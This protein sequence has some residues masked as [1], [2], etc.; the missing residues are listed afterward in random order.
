VQT[1]GSGGKSSDPGVHQRVTLG[2]SFDPKSNSLN[3]LRLVLATVVLAVHAFALGAFGREPLLH[4][5][6]FAS[7]AVYGFFGISGFLIAGSAARN[8]PGRYLWQ[9]FLRIFPGFWVCLLMTSF[10]FGALAWASQAHG[11]CGA[12]CYVTLKG[13]P[14]SYVY[15]NFLLKMNQTYVVPSAAHGEIGRLA[16]GSLWTLFYEFLCYLLLL[17]L[18]LLG[19]IRRRG[20]TLALS[21]VL[22]VV[23][24][25][26]T[27]TP[28]LAS[29]FGIHSHWVEMNF[30]MFANIFLVGAVISLYRDRIPDSGL[31]ALACTVVLIGSF[32]LP[33][34]TPA[35]QF[36]QSDLLLP[37]ITYPL[38]WLGIHLPF[39]RVG[40][41]NDY[42]YGIYIYAYPVTV[43]LT[44]WHAQQWGYV[45][46][47]AL[48]LLA[49][50][51]FAIASW[52]LLEKRALRLKKIDP[53]AAWQWVS[54]RRPDEI[55]GT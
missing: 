21:I 47:L 15:R 22:W 8:R 26:I 34:A 48:V 9:R 45:P 23:V 42:S 35:Q 11:H 3:L 5:T 36:A 44:L 14:I 7:I 32:W 4:N 49:T 12:G 13:G 6:D 38:I 53:R 28:T 19:M 39:Q 31:L 30:L 54:M 52:W 27:L 51:P 29:Q 25:V 20:L 50:A 17:A 10:F 33:G 37:L 43:I 16:N 46:F 55:V 18:S 41:R 24:S 1:V 40:A 2:E